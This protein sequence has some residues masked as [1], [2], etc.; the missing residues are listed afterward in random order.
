MVN[1]EFFC[2]TDPRRATQFLLEGLL[3]RPRRGVPEKYRR[4]RSDVS[5]STGGVP[6]HAAKI[7]GTQEI[8]RVGVNRLQQW[9]TGGDDGAA[10]VGFHRTGGGPKDRTFGHRA[11][12]SLTIFTG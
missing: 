9:R 7:H 1:G 8:V 5:A 6:V 4:N 11:A 3:K 12:K 10:Q 2:T